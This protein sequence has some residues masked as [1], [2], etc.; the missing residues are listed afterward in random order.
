L[1]ENKVADGSGVD[2]MKWGNLRILI[3]E[4]NDADFLLAERLLVA[5]LEGGGVTVRRARALEECFRSLKQ[6][7]ADMVLLDLSL[8]DSSGW[9]TFA[10][11]RR[12]APD[13][14][15]VLLTGIADEA[16][17]MNALS[18]GAEDYLVKDGLTSAALVRAIRYA[19]ERHRAE[20]ALRRNRAEL[21]V[22]VA[23][24]NRELQETNRRLSEALDRLKAHERELIRFE[25]MNALGEMAGSVMHQFN[26]LLMPIIG[27]S[28]MLL[29]SPECL[30]DKGSA[31]DMLDR[32]HKSAVSSLE[33]IRRMQQFCRPADD[34][35]RAIL[36]VNGMIEQV[37]DATRCRWL[38][39]GRAQGVSLAIKTDFDTVPPV[40]GRESQLREALANLLS[41]AMDAMPQGG[42][43]T[44]RTESNGESVGI[45]VSDTGTGMPDHVRQ[46]CLEPFFSTKGSQASGLGLS[47]VYG[48]VRDHGGE[49][50]I[51][52]QEGRGTSIKMNLPACLGDR[53]GGAVGDASSRQ[54][55]TFANYGSV[56]ERP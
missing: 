46:R 44:L 21:E 32:I 35:S 19:M 12:G 9:D 51:D 34:E 13:Q 10:R 37:V 18:M 40:F 52:S 1:L 7:P 38:E 25:R 3:V 29:E 24:R 56:T 22:T 30:D 54:E 33:V 15:V 17:A 42:V 39:A 27:Y 50:Q 41:N 5:G 49:L 36:E 28:E 45:E 43:V 55:Q 4:D 2:A 48:I 47:L 14:V 26:N 53:A 20:E 6:D 11:F 8:P 16:G 23:E 31:L